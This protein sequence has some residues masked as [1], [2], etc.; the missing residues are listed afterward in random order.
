VKPIGFGF[1]AQECNSF[2]GQLAQVGS[3]GRCWKGRRRVGPR[4]CRPS[5]ARRLR[6]AKFNL[7]GALIG[8]NGFDCSFDEAGVAAKT[9]VKATSTPHFGGAVA[10][11]MSAPAMN[12]VRCVAVRTK[13]ARPIIF[14]SVVVGGSGWLIPLRLLS[15]RHLPYGSLFIVFA[16]GMD[17]RRLQHFLGHAS[18]T[19]TVRYTAMSPEPF[20]NIWR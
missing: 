6:C 17:T 2:V 4:C 9:L 18:I 7:H 16:R 19:N 8:F 11:E 13:K 3:C 15:V 10:S 5:L 14:V 1:E 12:E 20:K